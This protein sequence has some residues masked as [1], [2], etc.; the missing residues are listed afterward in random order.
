MRVLAA[1]VGGTNARLAEVEVDGAAIRVMRERTFP[2]G[3]YPGLA[4]I[5]KTFLADGGVELAAA[6]IG[7]AG[8][9][10]DG[11]VRTSNLPWVVSGHA[12]AREIA[13]P[14]THLINDL[15]ATARGIARL[16][17]RDLVT[18]QA[19]APQE[20]GVMAL[21]G[22]GTGLGEAFAVWDGGRYRT[23][24]SEGGHVT[25]A[26]RDERERDL[27]RWLAERYGHVSFERVLSGPGLVNIFQFLADRAMPR[28]EAAI[29]AVAEEGAAAVS[30][31]ALAGTS[32][33]AREALDLFV[34]AYGGQA[35][36]LALTVLSTG[37]LY[38][39]GGIA[40]A[41]VR[42]LVDGTFM[43]AFR[44]KGRLAEVL[45]AMPVHVVMN[46]DTGLYGAA[47]AAWEAVTTRAPRSGA[48][49]TTT[50]P[51]GAG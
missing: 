17:A 28:D 11:E 9:V 25:F 33:V 4:P 8:P 49:H 3:D 46:G 29:N 38:V 24:P 27:H 45:A 42:K 13:I 15:D 23:H 7:I 36:N 50:N 21:I 48:P 14:H 2:S 37:G 30:R 26:P 39:V 1:D 51:V 19:G 34:S 6:C 35:G 32:H 20:H 44:A 31:L 16:T 5:V 18:L 47:V 41:I 40:P 22:A 10:V 43:A 12:L